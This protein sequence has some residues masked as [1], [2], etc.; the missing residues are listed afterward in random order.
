MVELVSILIGAAVG[1]LLGVGIGVVLGTRVLGHSGP[2]AEAVLREPAT[3]LGV[4]PTRQTVVSEVRD[5]TATIDRLVQALDAGARIDRN[6]P[7]VDRL[8]AVTD[9]VERGDVGVQRAPPDNTDER[10]SDDGEDDEQLLAFEEFVDA[11]VSV[12]ADTQVNT[13]DSERLLRYLSDPESASQDQ[14]AETLTTTVERLETA[15]VVTD[16]LPDRGSR[17]DPSRVADSV[18]RDLRGVEG[19]LADGADAL[20][21]HLAR[22]ADQLS[23]CET[24]R[25]DLQDAAARICTVADNQT[26]L[27]FSGP[28]SA[29]ARA[30]TLADALND[31]TVMLSD[32]G[33]S[34]ADVATAAKRTVAPE[35][36]LATRLVDGLAD[37]DT[38]D[39]DRFRTTLENVLTTIDETEAVRGRLDAVDREQVSTLAEDLAEDLEGASKEVESYLLD[40]VQDLVDA[41]E[42]SNEADA[43]TAY[44]AKQELRYYDRTLLPQLRTS[45]GEGGAD[46]DTVDRLL[47]EVEDRR[48][49]IRT[50]Y[51]SNYPDHNHNIP[52][53]FL[54]LVEQLHDQAND[55][56]LQGNHQRALG[57][58][59]AANQVLDWIEQLYERHAY[60]ALLQQLR[61]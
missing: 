23:E 34:V 37:Q 38:V 13:R 24:V 3:E 60:S 15:A 32:S 46:V 51:P 40:R 58:L 8:R 44:A 41:I 25:D 11:A 57:L 45:S 21:D 29:T 48:S 30:G 59:E 61:G 56:T 49:T 31:G 50:Q 16:T 27:Q 10:E 20:A 39:E 52:I 54:E 28:E 7:P 4:A 9:A 53:H 26:S 12:Q 2:D 1:L 42:R 43:L 14:F 33:D 55:A 6:A 36:K 22:T 19:E 18:Q 17:R 47:D 5:L 35:S